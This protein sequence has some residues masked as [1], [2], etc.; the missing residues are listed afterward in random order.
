M[1]DFFMNSIHEAI[2]KADT[3]EENMKEISE[4]FSSLSQ[5]FINIS[6]NRIDIKIIKK[7][8]ALPKNG[9][10]AT[11]VAAQMFLNQTEPYNALILEN[12]NNTLTAELAEVIY[13]EDG[14]PIRLKIK[15]NTKT[16][17]DK[18]S[19]IEGLNEVIKSTEVGK[20][21]KRLLD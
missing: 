8:R 19:L 21:Y 6:N 3:A 18:E 14:Y 9:L 20:A 5:S 12:I 13:S 16:Y 2:E 4:V 7:N 11:A 15:D 1:T 17:Y 10:L